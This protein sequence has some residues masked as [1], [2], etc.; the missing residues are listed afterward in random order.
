MRLDRLERPALSR[1]FRAEGLRGA[2]GPRLSG[3]NWKS[4]ILCGSHNPRL[5]SH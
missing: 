2:L 4:N 1:S 3:I 5:P